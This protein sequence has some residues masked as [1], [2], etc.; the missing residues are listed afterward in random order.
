MLNIK[1]INMKFSAALVSMV[2]L[3]V[4][5]FSLS[6]SKADA[7]DITL[8]YNAHNARTGGY[9]RQ[10]SL[11]VEGNNART[12]IGN[13]D[14]V[15]D[16]SKNGVVKIITNYGLGSG[17]VVDEHTIAT[18]AHCVYNQAISSILFFD[19]DGNNSMTITNPVEYHIPEKYIARAG[20]EYTYETS[21][22]DYALI[23]VK[24]SLKDYCCFDF[25]M[26]TKQ[27]PDLSTNAIS[28]SGFPG[29]VKGKTVN[30][31]EKHALYTGTGK[32]NI[33]NSENTGYVDLFYYTNDFTPGNSGGPIYVNEQI[34]GQT[35][36]TVVGIAVASTDPQ[37]VG[38]AMSPTVLKFLRGNSNKNY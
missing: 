19:K 3:F 35:Y 31:Y 29:S 24:Q 16:Y 34:N 26:M 8:K 22:Y 10:Y 23:T 36:Y 11:T 17:F 25:G 18:A 28:V 37:N 13:D 21:Y 5:V 15:I 30:D 6:S 1:K 14:R 33:C 2:V 27:F 9:L 7:G 4:T 32:V 38:T 20:L 12:V